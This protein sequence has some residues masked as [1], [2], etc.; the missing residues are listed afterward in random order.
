MRTPRFAVLALL[1]FCLVT[2]LHAQRQTGMIRGIV[3]ASDGTP[4]PG[5]SLTL[6]GP[7][8]IGPAA[9]VSNEA[10]AFRLPGLP[11]GEF[12]LVAE[13][14]GFK[15]FKREGLIVSVG[16]TVD[17]RI[18]LEQSE[19]STEVDVVAPSPAVD[20]RNTKVVQIIADDVM[21]NLPGRRNLAAA[22]TSSPASCPAEGSGGSRT[23]GHRTATPF[24]MTVSRRILPIRA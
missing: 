24:S 22:T 3:A 1:V 4:L 10:G 23:A 20:V 11:P 7:T 6:K 15:A 9:A 14:S 18:A 16:M 17:I 2:V 5:V 19:I 21:K 13:I 12:V 8:L